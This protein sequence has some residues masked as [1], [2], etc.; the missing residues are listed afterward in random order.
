MGNV[1]TMYIDARMSDFVQRKLATISDS[2]EPKKIERVAT[3][4]LQYE[5][6]NT[7]SQPVTHGG[8]H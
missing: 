5:A 3:G 2:N 8:R 1:H 6:I 7:S 4:G